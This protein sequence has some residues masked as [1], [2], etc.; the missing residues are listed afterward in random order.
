[1]KKLLLF[2]LVCIMSFGMKA[3]TLYGDVNGD[4]AV[5]ISD[6]NSVINDILSDKFNANSDVNDDGVVN[7]SDLNSIINVILD[8]PIV[9]LY[10]T[11]IV[12][13]T[14]GTTVEYLIDKHSK[15]QISDPFLVINTNGMMQVFYLEKMA[16]LRYGQRLVTRGVGIFRDYK[17]TGVGSVFLNDLKDDT[18]VEVTSTDG[19]VVCSDRYS[20]TVEITLSDEPAGEYVITA[21]SETL[22]IVKP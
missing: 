18:L 5:T 1:M 15:I 3:Q 13:T 19:R 21:G 17:P 6:V 12:T 11:I 14:D 16:Q 2:L 7:I 22:K 8:Q 10:S 4:N 9:Q 20:G